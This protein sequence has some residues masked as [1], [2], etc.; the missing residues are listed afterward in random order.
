MYTVGDVNIPPYSGSGRNRSLSAQAGPHRFIWDLH[1]QP[2]NVP[3]SYPISAVYGNTAPSPTSPWVHARIVYTVRL[4]ANGKKSDSKSLTVQMDPRVT[5]T[6][7]DLQLQHVIWRMRA[8]RGIWDSAMM[9]YDGVR[10]LRAEIT[11]RSAGAEA[12]ALC[13]PWTERTRST[14]RRG[15]GVGRR[16]RAGGASGAMYPS[17]SSCR[18][19]SP[20]WGLSRT[21]ICRLLH[22]RLRD[23]RQPKKGQRRHGPSGG[24]LNGL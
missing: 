6:R 3:V 23:W 20:R 15:A 1:Y 9:A 4:T 18:D 2:L 16:G 24:I 13:A 21:R 8:Y 5:T 17:H 22:R 11:K 7:A 19:S 10:A 12:I 14:G